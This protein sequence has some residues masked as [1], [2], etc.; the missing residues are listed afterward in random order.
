M[1]PHRVWE[2][3]NSVRGLQTPLI[4]DNSKGIFLT[5]LTKWGGVLWYIAL[6]FMAIGWRLR[7]S[8]MP[9]KQAET[10]QIADFADAI[11]SNRNP[12]CNG[13]QARHALEVYERIIKSSDAGR[14]VDVASRFPAP[15]PVGDVAPWEDA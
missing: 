14:P 9:P 15:Q 1:T 11:R 13:A 10:N 8:Y 4:T 2:V 6:F 7:C 5:N 3:P 12:R